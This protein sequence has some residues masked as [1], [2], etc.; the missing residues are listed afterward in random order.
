[1]VREHPAQLISDL[2]QCG[3][4]AVEADALEVRLVEL[5][6]ETVLYAVYRQ[7]VPGPGLCDTITGD[8]RFNV[9]RYSRAQI[10]KVSHDRSVRPQMPE[11]PRTQLVR[12]FRLIDARFGAA[13]PAGHTRTVVYLSQGRSDVLGQKTVLSVSCIAH[14]IT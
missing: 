10:G 9:G 11:V 1:M 2:L 13:A 8:R 5:T 7:P 4:V 14:L 3:L 12:S 6:H